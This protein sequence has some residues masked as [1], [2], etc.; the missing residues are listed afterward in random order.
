MRRVSPPLATQP[1]LLRRPNQL[2][3]QGAPPSM[4]PRLRPPPIHCLTFP[5]RRGCVQPSRRLTSR[6]RRRSC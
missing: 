2:K 3:L 4:P 1:R 6:R 5:S